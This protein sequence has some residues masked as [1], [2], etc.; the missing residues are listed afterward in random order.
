M[1]PRARDAH[2]VVF[3]R[4]YIIII[5]IIPLNYSNSKCPRPSTAH[6]HDPHALTLE[7]LLHRYRVGNQLLYFTRRTAADAK[8]QQRKPTKLMIIVTAAAAAVYTH[9]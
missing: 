9:T 7:T 5:I 2:R 1:I 3:H 8:R 4:I 6:K